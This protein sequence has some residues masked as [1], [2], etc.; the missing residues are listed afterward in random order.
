MAV[1]P[2]I[3]PIGV[4]AFL[5]FAS[6][7][8]QAQAASAPPFVVGDNKL[9]C[10]A[11]TDGLTG[12][13]NALLEDGDEAPYYLTGAGTVIPGAGI[14]VDPVAQED[15]D[16]HIPLQPA[17]AQTIAIGGTVTA[18]AFIGSGAY[19][20][21]IA[22]FGVSLM[23]GTAVL[24]SAEPVDHQMAPN[25]GNVPGGTGPYEEIT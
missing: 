14:G 21:G 20:G 15:V 8:V 9:Y 25:N 12:W 19:G 23:A 10:H 18:Q 11:T 5:L 7:N 4:I 13:I 3:L 17:L 6:V 16:A 2:L 24:G 1:R 22:S